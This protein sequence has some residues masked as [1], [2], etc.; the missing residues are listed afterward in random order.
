MLGKLS[1]GRKWPHVTFNLRARPFVKCSIEGGSSVLGRLA[2]SLPLPAQSVC[3][4]GH[5]VWACATWSVLGQISSDSLP[6]QFNCRFSVPGVTASKSQVL[7]RQIKKKD[8]EVKGKKIW[9]VP[10]Q[11]TLYLLDL[12]FSNNFITIPWQFFSYLAQ[13][14]KKIDTSFC[15]VSRSICFK[16][17]GNMYSSFISYWRMCIWRITWPQH[18]QFKSSEEHFHTKRYNTNSI[19]V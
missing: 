18:H 19:D 13:I 2:P 3:A 6:A 12:I 7:F 4:Y 10:P 9:T 1:A 16:S 14:I 8:E 5:E 17:R 15:K 11:E